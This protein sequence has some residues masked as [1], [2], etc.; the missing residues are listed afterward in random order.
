MDEGKII[1]IS[2]VSS[3]VVYPFISPYCASKKALDIFFQALDIEL[4]NPKIKIVSIKPSV[5]QTPIWQKSYMKAQQRF[6]KLPFNIREKYSKRFKKLLEKSEANI[7]HGLKPEEVA[8]LVLKILNSQ[9]PKSSYCIGFGSYIG[10][11]I[12]KLSP[13][14]QIKIAKILSK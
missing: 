3:N 5:V 13:E 2:S 7:K 6:E 8:K 11:F 10:V 4:N 9:K 14:L 12:N 1:N